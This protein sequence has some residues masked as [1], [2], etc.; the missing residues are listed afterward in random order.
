[1]IGARGVSARGNRGSRRCRAALEAKS[2]AAGAAARR[3]RTGDPVRAPRGE[4]TRVVDWPRLA[5]ATTR[6]TF[7]KRGASRSPRT[8]LRC[9][10]SGLPRGSTSR[11]RGAYSRRRCVAS[12]RPSGDAVTMHALCRPRSVSA[13]ALLGDAY[14]VERPGREHELQ[15]TV[16]SPNGASTR[17]GGPSRSSARRR[18]AHRRVGA[19]RR[20]RHRR[21]P[22]HARSFP[23]RAPVRGAAI[24]RARASTVSIELGSPRCVA[25]QGR[26]ATARVP[27]ATA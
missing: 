27:A 26:V 3:A 9:R 16:E 5:W 6:K 1:V 15:S 23:P 18:S 19:G 12:P 10:G 11:R 20:G 17:A 21:R 7:L 14:P 8:A 13:P 2:R 22:Q 4:L 24:A 25:T